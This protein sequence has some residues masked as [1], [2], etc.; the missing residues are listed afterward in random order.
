MRNELFICECHYP[1]HQMI[2]SY[3]DN[4][5]DGWDE[6][7]VEIHLTTYMGFWKRLWHGIKYIFGYKSPYG[8]FDGLT[9]NPDDVDKLQDV[10]NYL[11]IA[12]VNKDQ[13]R[14]EETKHGIDVTLNV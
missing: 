13:H 5:N 11:K 7:N 8:A 14:R 2:I 6:V 4:D 10:V 1:A 12:K 3:D 9:I